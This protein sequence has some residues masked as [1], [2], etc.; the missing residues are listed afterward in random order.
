MLENEKD[1]DKIIQGA[2]PYSDRDNQHYKAR[3]DKTSEEELTTFMLPSNPCISGMARL[4]ERTITTYTPYLFEVEKNGKLLYSLEKPLDKYFRGRTFQV[5]L[6]IV[7]FLRER[8]V[9]EQIIEGKAHKCLVVSS[10]D[11]V[12]WLNSNIEAD[13]K[14]DT[15]R[16]Q[17]F[18]AKERFNAELNRIKQIEI[19]RRLYSENT[20]SGDK[21][22]KLSSQG[23]AKG[24]IFEA[25]TY[26]KGQLFYL[27]LTNWFVEEITK[28]GTAREFPIELL[29]PDFENCA[30]LGYAIYY[31]LSGNFISKEQSITKPMYM[32][33]ALSYCPDIP[34]AK[35]VK[36]KMNYRYKQEI[37]EPFLERIQTLNKINGLSIHLADESKRKV[38]I[39]DVLKM[40]IE[41]FLKLNLITK[42]DGMR[43]LSETQL[44]KL[45][46]KE[47]K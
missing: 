10:Q 33:T 44:K 12:K 29:H 18:R 7:A 3:K 31:S 20:N 39:Y 45:S 2:E 25:T 9:T 35:E 19:E 11:I 41:Q 13:K 40:P 4:S 37:I 16:K 17:I 42:W 26:T 36:E 34:S 47:E 5:F 14:N 23:R 46:Q 38:S 27:P 22:K 1:E 21:K 30:N 8:G 32:N 24:G 6:A 15:V 43:F 28:K